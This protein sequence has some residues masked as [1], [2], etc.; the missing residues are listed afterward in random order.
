MQEENRWARN[1]RE[2]GLAFLLNA[3]NH[4]YAKILLDETSLRNLK[5]KLLLIQ[6]KVNRRT[7]FSIYLDLVKDGKIKSIE[8]AK[9]ATT[10][11]QNEID[12]S[13]I[14]DIDIV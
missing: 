12:P 6:D 5:N 4:T 13:F 9:Y 1:D 3:N 8:F 7:V 10:T 2:S 14:S 11:L